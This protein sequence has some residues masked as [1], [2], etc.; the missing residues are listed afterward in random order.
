MKNGKD[1][2][3]QDHKAS[4]ASG[5]SSSLKAGYSGKDLMRQ[6]AIEVLGNEWTSAQS[7][8]GEKHAKKK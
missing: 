7:D 5:K 6:R 8:K 2:S 3:C 4:K 1:C